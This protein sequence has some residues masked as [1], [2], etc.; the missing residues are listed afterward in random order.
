[1]VTASDAE[2]IRLSPPGTAAEAPDQPHGHYRFRPGTPTVVVNLSHLAAP[3]AGER[4]H[5]WARLDGRTIALGTATPDEAGKAILVAEDPA[6]ASRP[7]EVWVTLGERR[8]LAS[9]R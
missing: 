6:L 8:V 2:R 3:P 4:Y 1:M 7:D 5:A 9:T